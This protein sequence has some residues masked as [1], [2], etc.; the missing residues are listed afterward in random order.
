MN[1][2]ALQIPNA[3]APIGPYSQAI[4]ANGMLFIS[5]QCPINPKT[6]L[7]EMETIESAT[8]LVMSNIEKLLH[9][10]EMD[11]THIVKCSIFLKDLGDFQKVNTI[12]ATYFDSVPPARET[13]EVARLPLDSSIEIS[14]IAMKS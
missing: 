5:G 4:L 6:G 1:K 3:P 7:L 11:F 12:Y 8:H 13:V 14:C 9:A 2:K 10:A